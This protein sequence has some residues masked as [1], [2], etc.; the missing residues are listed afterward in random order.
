MIN[1][2]NSNHEPEL[3]IISGM[4]VIVQGK[5]SN[6]MTKII[7]LKTKRNLLKH[8]LLKIMGQLH[9]LNSELEDQLVVPFM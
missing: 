8:S 5:P 9:R 6:I 2:I 1:K 3:E 4:M 7:I